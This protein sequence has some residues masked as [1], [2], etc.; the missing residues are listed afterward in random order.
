MHTL[1]NIAGVTCIWVQITQVLVYRMNL[2]ANF[3]GIYRGKSN[4]SQK[5]SVIF[6]A[7]YEV[8]PLNYFFK[9]LTLHSRLICQP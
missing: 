9:K 3:S 5:L 8:K 4:Y 7:S 1:H 6:L 2:L